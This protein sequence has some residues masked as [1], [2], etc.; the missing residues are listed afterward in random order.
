MI[1]S[2]ET[3]RISTVSPVISGL[4]V[5]IIYNTPTMVVMLEISVVMDWFMPCPR[6]STSLVMRLS[7]SPTV[8]FSKYF[9]GI[10]LIFSVISRRIR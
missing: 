1:S 3:G 4:M 10:R 9:M 8:R 6:V 2:R 5:S 7:T